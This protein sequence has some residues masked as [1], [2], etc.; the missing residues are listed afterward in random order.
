MVKLFS[1]VILSFL[2]LSNSLRV[3]LVYSW[4]TLD[5]DSFIEQLCENKDKPELACD[6]KC[7]LST[8]I[9]ASSATSEEQT[10][11]TLEWEQLVYCFQISAVSEIVSSETVY[12]K[13][14]YHFSLVPEGYSASIFHPPKEV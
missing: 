12:Q 11:P 4:Y 1:V 8:M 3:S 5:I 2:V 14:F 7:Y 6:G 10:M 13:R 9:Q